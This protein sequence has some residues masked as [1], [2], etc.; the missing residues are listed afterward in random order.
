MAA[1]LGLLGLPPRDEL[2][3]PSPMSRFPRCAGFSHSA[4]ARREDRGHQLFRNFFSDQRF[5][6]GPGIAAE[7]AR[8]LVSLD[9]VDARVTH[10]E[11]A[12]ELGAAVGLQLAVEI[13]M[14]E[15]DQLTASDVRPGGHSILSPE[16]RIKSHPYLGCH[17]RRNVTPGG[18]SEIRG[19]PHA[20]DVSLDHVSAAVGPKDQVESL[21][22]GNIV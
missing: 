6:L 10:R 14:Q 16:E 5:R 17:R 8:S 7:R 3:M 2:W 12:I 4:P 1:R 21:V 11:V 22:P 18:W 13:E 20:Q 19:L 15:L 9:V